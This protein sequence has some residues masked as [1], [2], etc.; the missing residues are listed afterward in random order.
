MK[1][2]E[3]CRHFLDSEKEHNKY[4]QCRR[5]APIVVQRGSAGRSAGLWHSTEWPTV[6]NHTKSCGELEPNTE[7]Q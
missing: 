3:D 4:P 6:W 7:K 2:C 5:Y 1:T